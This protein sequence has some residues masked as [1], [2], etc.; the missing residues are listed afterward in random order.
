MTRE[1]SHLYSVLAG[2]VALWVSG[3]TPGIGYKPSGILP[4]AR[5]ELVAVRAFVDRRSPPALTGR[6][7]LRYDDAG[8]WSV[9]LDPTRYI[10]A[11]DDPRRM[12]EECPHDD[13]FHDHADEPVAAIVTRAV[14]AGLKA[15][16][17]AVD[18]P[19]GS[20]VA[21]TGDLVRFS[22]G[23]RRWAAQ[24]PWLGGRADHYLATGN[25]EIHIEVRE[26]VTGRVLYARSYARKIERTDS[27]YPCTLDSTI[28][29]ARRALNDALGETI[30]AVVNDEDLI[31]HM[32]Q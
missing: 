22:M 12:Y 9:S 11:V 30:G 28:R 16:G 14:V 21:V 24:S 8:H 23:G 17:F 26:P 15:K 18:G 32:R 6:C 20:G 1:R 25:C 27:C 7:F 2:L 10:G 29:H 13:L 4:V 3:C 19:S 31:R 5:G